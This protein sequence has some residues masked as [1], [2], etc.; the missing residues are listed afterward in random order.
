MTFQ[1]PNARMQ[2]TT[3][4]PPGIKHSRESQ[5]EKPALLRM[6]QN[7]KRKRAK[8]TRDIQTTNM[9]RPT[10]MPVDRALVVDVVVSEVSWK[11]ASARASEAMKSP[12]FL[13]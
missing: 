11:I 8:K 4:A 10:P 1:V 9:P 13:R 6:R 5:P 2:S 3:I 7:R 12:F